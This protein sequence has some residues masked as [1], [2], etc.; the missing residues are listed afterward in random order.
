[1]PDLEP[2]TFR[3]NVYC[4]NHYTTTLDLKY[5]VYFFTGYRRKDDAK[6][7]NFNETCE[8]C[9]P[10]H[11]GN[12]PNRSLCQICRGGVICFEGV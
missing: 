10:G 6:G 2:L 11:Y 3:L 7:K 12:H 4:A 8:I 1:M 5:I 9:R